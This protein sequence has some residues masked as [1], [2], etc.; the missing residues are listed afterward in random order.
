MENLPELSVKKQILEW[1]NQSS[2]NT[3]LLTE[4]LQGYHLPSSRYEVASYDWLLRGVALIDEVPEAEALFAARVA[5]L[6]D[7]APEAE[8]LDN[9]PQEILHNLLRLCSA[10]R[11]RPQLG[12]ALLRMYGR[13]MDNRPIT[14]PSELRFALTNALIFNQHDKALHNVWKAMLSGEKHE[15]LI[16]NQVTGAEAMIWSTESEAT[17]GQPNY[18]ATGYA[19]GKIAHYLKAEAIAEPEA[20]FRRLLEM[21]KQIYAIPEEKWY[22][23]MAEQSYRNSW[24]DWAEDLL[25]AD[26]TMETYVRL[27]ED[28]LNDWQPP[29]SIS[30]KVETINRIVVRAELVGK[31]TQTIKGLAATAML[32][33]ELEQGLKDSQT[34]Q[35]IRECRGRLFKYR[36]DN[37]V[38]REEFS[39]QHSYDAVHAYAG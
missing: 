4:W 35:R 29:S 30:I 11:R 37:C 25:P 32:K 24:P 6:L 18:N 1:L 34:Q 2:P 33:L 8:P 16:G 28:W 19:L 22:R 15:L 20:S 13:L 12:P 3:Q 10:L 21:G 7:E 5:D 23:K 17:W 39:R 27:L 14:L 31:K 36:V 26:I 9:Q 38:K